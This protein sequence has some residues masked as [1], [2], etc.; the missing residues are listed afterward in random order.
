[1]EEPKFKIVGGLSLP[2]QITIASED[3]SATA[4]F[5]KYDKDNRKFVIDCSVKKITNYKKDYLPRTISLFLSLLSS[6]PLFLRALFLLMII[7]WFDSL[8]QPVSPLA[9]A[10]PIS[11]I[12]VVLFS[13]C[14]H[15]LILMALV[16]FLIA[17]WHGSEHMAISAYEK[18]G[19]SSIG[20]I[21]SQ[22]TVHPKCGGRL[23]VPLMA[24]FMLDMFLR[25]H[26]LLGGLIFALAEILT[27]E[28]ALQID[29]WVGF[30]KIPLFS[31]ASIF[32]QKYFTTK[33][34]DLREILT[35]KAALDALI[36]AHSGALEALDF[37]V[38]ID[39][40]GIGK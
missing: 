34:P 36:L 3:Y 12:V 6:L 28:L 18:T 40:V 15:T 10:M 33:R 39:D 11:D 37:E 7:S 32:I 29:K 13:T 8:I 31:Q 2:R 17:K 38:A 19:T 20:V 9:Q 23:F 35:G 1:M 26:F 21:S 14:L 22:S 30:D 5:K 27:L 25:N 4:A 16:R 24:L